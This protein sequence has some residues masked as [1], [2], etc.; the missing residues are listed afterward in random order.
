MN[1]LALGGADGVWQDVERSEAILGEQWWGLVVACNRAGVDWPGRLDAWCSLHPEKLLSVWAP[2][3]ITDEYETWSDPNR[4][5][6]GAAPTD[7]HLDNWG[8]S[9]G[10]FAVQVALEVGADRV[11]AC[12][13][14]MDRRAHYHGTAAWT[15]Y[16]NF[17]AAWERKADEL[18]PHVKSMS[19]WTRELLG[20]PT[21]AW[22]D[23]QVARVA[24]TA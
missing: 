2:A 14:P 5:E 10:L 8:G 4:G 3:R 12:G 17:R 20:T 1:A 23:T 15:E 22:I 7:H 21:R 6:R 13:M 19:G 16:E 18:E 9:S 11:V 24:Q